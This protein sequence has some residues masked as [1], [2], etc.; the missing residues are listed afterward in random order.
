[1][2]THKLPLDQISSVPFY[3]RHFPFV[4]WT[5]KANLQTTLIFARNLFRELG[6]LRGI[7]FW[8]VFPFRMV[9]TYFKYR[10]GFNLVYS[11][12]R[13]MGFMQWIA[14]V[15]VYEVLER[16]TGQEQAYAFIKHAIQDASK[17]LMSDLYQA[18]R[19]AEFEDPFEAFWAYH[20]AMFQGDPN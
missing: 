10:K 12:F 6:L 8:L 19:L 17:V 20:K 13:I 18:D 7:G 11:K 9:P 16:K 3:G 4:P 14:V 2:T 1:M 15:S 5:F